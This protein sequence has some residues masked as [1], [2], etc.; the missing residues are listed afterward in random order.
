MFL[1]NCDR[2]PSLKALINIFYKLYMYLFFKIFVKYNKKCTY[3]I[4]RTV[5]FR[6]LFSEIIVHVLIKNHC[7]SFFNLNIDG[8]LHT[9]SKGMTQTSMFH[10]FFSIFFYLTTTLFTSLVSTCDRVKGP[11]DFGNGTPKL[12]NTDLGS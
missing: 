1:G 3:V 10:C 2:L 6:Q 9:L 4:T 12:A 8:K 11:Y 7:K 5:S